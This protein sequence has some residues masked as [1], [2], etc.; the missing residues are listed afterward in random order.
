VRSRLF[1]VVGASGVGKDSLLQFA[2]KSLD[3]ADAVLFAHRY[4]TRP[5][6]PDGENH[7]AL[8]R[9]EF[10]LRQSHGL[11]AMAWQSHGFHYGIGVEID[12]WLSQ[13][14]TVVV[15]GSRSYEPSARRRYVQMKVIWISAAPQVLATRLLRRGRES[16]SEISAR[17][18]RNAKLGVKPPAGALHI[19]NEGA[20]EDAGGRLVAILARR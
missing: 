13:G 4:I 5:V 1:Y 15:N 14:L 18:E 17:L 19:S 3:E 11:F 2:R 9:A 10:L 16:G 6:E 8:T 12:A 20:L 7:V